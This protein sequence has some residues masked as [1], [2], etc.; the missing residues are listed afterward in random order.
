VQGP[1]RHLDGATAEEIDRWRDLEGLA[2]A[3]GTAWAAR[4]CD[5]L[6]RQGRSIA[7]GWPGTLSQARLRLAMCMN[8]RS[9]KPIGALSAVDLDWLA[10]T[11]YL[12]AKSEWLARAEPGSDE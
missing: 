4:S 12:S 7:G 3:E 8:G 5:E 11:L 6:R 2:A 9:A 10:W 1:G